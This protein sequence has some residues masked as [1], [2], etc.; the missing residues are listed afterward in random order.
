MIVLKSPAEIEKMRVSGRIAA[1]ILE[2][3]RQAV[4]PGVTTGSL[5]VLAERIIKARG[6]TSA[7]L[8]YHDYPARICV[9]LNEEVVHG[10]P[11][12]RAILEGALVSIDVGVYKDGYCGDTAATFIVGDGGRANQR[13]VQTA[14]RALEEAIQKATAQY[15][16]F[17]I[18]FAIESCAL[19]G[20]YAVVRDFV[21]HGIGTKMHED[22]QVPNFGRPGSG[23]RLKE[24]MVL[25]IEPMLN[26]GTHEVEVLTDG[27]TVV[28][29]DRKP[30][31]HF[32]HTVAIT[33]RGAEVLTCLKRNPSR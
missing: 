2:E 13:L 20:G 17:D 21:G 5:D 18:S 4:R 9:S 3:L 7:F 30:S 24:G 25:A 32:E 6:A 22:P 26:A 28:T 14:Q 29:K 8:G 12:K 1:E 27:W 19:A 23:P 31:A 10:I 16:L 11:G 33:A 15:R